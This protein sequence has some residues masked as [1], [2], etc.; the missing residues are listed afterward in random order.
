[1]AFRHLL[2][3][4]SVTVRC[5]KDVIVAG[6]D[7]YPEMFLFCGCESGNI[8]VVNIMREM[9]LEVRSLMHPS[10]WVCNEPTV[11]LYAY[12]Q[13]KLFIWVIFHLSSVCPSIFITQWVTRHVT[14]LITLDLWLV[15]AEK[16][17]TT[18]LSILHKKAAECG[19][20]E[21][22]GPLGSSLLCLAQIPGFNLGPGISCLR[23]SAFCVCPA[24]EQENAWNAFIA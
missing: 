4:V 8:L 13:K 19:L 23:V 9:A 16:T 6:R 5:F 15:F 17:P 2:R 24:F 18:Q 7:L 11:N 1:V 22:C 10:L 21:L 14:V 12:F 20:T 3:D